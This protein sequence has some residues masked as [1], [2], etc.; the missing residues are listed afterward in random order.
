MKHIKIFKLYGT[1]KNDLSTVPEDW[2][3]QE[4]Q[5]YYKLDTDTD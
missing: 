4:S 2:N 3:K 1:N 5:L